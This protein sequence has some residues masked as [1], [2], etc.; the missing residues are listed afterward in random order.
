MARRM[1]LVQEQARKQENENARLLL[2]LSKLQKAQE[3]LEGSF[4]CLQHPIVHAHTHC[5]GVL[6]T[7][8][9]PTTASHTLSIIVLAVRTC[10]C[11][12]VQ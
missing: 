7:E 6:V 8:E 12:I 3:E 11:T 9:V 5:A 2:Q 4:R 10:A 1:A